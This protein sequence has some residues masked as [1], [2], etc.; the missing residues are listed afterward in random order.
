MSL[1]VKVMAFNGLSARRLSIILSALFLHS[2]WAA[3]E[4]SLTFYVPFPEAD[5]LTAFDTINAAAVLPIT[6]YVSI[7][8]ISDG[9]II[10]YDHWE[11]G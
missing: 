3:N 6:T 10:Y 8:A 4:P 9:T 5:A 2:A 1:A 7:A 11:D